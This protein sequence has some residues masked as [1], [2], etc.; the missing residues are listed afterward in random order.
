MQSIKMLLGFMGELFSR[1]SVIYE[2]TKRD[3]KTAYLGSYLGIVWAF[4]LPLANVLIFWFIF[5]IGF[6]S[7]PVENVPYALWLICGM[8]P[9]FFFSDCT[10]NSANS[11]LQNGFV[12]KKVAFS[13][14]MLPLIKIL[15]ALIIHF[16]FILLILIVFLANG[17]SLDIH[18]L[19]VFYY[20]L[21]M[22][23][24][25]TGLSWLTSSV[26]LFFR[27]LRHLI[28]I[29]LQVGF[30]LTPIFWNPKMF[31]DRF[32]SVIKANPMYYIIEGY[33][34]C[35]ITKVWFWEHGSLTL[36]FW[37]IA[38]LLL[39]CGALVFRRLRPHFAD[40]L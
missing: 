5:E 20:L 35:F 19:Q 2:L 26:I 7:K 31:P 16:F 11:I 33:R 38:I 8:V 37:I 10:N 27:D 24:F 18:M 23:V 22:T 4:A 14:G 1:R 25:L 34:D 9:W 40:V 29:M 32:Q 6:K 17:Y 12:V 13:I 28:S 21:A 36:Q 15:S 3:F 39:A 30:Y